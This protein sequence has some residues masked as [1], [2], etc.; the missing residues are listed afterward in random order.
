LI[1]NQYGGS[2]YFASWTGVG[3]ESTQRS[4]YPFCA[5][6][7]AAAAESTLLPGEPHGDPADR[8]LIA[9]AR[10]QGLALATRDEHIIEYGKLGF[11]RV[12]EL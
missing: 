9:T 8:F 12:V 11:L 5:A 4:W 6:G 3:R 10:T 2:L 7:A 1:P